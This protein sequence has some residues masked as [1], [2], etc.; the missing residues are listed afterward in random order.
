M[1]M[2]N[3]II[4]KKNNKTKNTHSQDSKK[5][6]DFTNSQLLNYST[7]TNQQHERTIKTNKI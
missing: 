1:L 6:T 3:S 7:T 5:Y 4:N 2:Q